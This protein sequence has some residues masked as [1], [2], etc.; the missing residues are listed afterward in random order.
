MYKNNFNPDFENFDFYNI[1][2]NKRYR[3]FNQASDD[4]TGSG[5]KTRYAQGNNLACSRYL[6]IWIVRGLDRYIF[7]WIYIQSNK[8]MDGQ[9]DR[10]ISG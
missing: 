7:K 2:F 4:V 9:L 10:W 3:N 5:R 1:E 6:D 8:W